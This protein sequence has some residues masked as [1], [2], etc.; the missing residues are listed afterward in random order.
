MFYYNLYIIHRKHIK[1]EREKRKEK[2]YNYNNNNKGIEL[3]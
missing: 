2:S 3:K 1:R